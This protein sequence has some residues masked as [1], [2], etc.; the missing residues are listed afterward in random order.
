MG[1]E[2]RGEGLRLRLIALLEDRNWHLR[3]KSFERLLQSIESWSAELERL[4]LGALPE[5]LSILGQALDTAFCCGCLMLLLSTSAT[6]NAG[7]RVVQLLLD[8]AE[9]RDVV[10]GRGLSMCECS[11]DVKLRL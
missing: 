4:H 11:F 2:L 5:V 1:I 9:R 3:P 10:R 6:S 7:N 8:S